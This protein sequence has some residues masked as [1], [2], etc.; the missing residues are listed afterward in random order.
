MHINE[1][2]FMYAGTSGYQSVAFNLTFDLASDAAIIY[3]DLKKSQFFKPTFDVYIKSQN[4]LGAEVW[5][6][7]VV[8]TI[9]SDQ[10]CVI[11]ADFFVVENMQI[12]LMGVVFNNFFKSIFG[13][14]ESDVNFFI[15]SDQRLFFRVMHYASIFVPKW[16][17]NKFD[18]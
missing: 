15:S 12:Y 14:A 18:C 10:Y 13:F 6:F 2:V 9:P 11:I 1:I 4:D 16:R 5:Y 7:L 3:D 17:N 8:L